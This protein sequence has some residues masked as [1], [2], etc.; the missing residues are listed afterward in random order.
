MISAYT[1]NVW[2]LP[3]NS[4]PVLAVGNVYCG[5]AEGRA[6]AKPLHPSAAGREDVTVVSLIR[7]AAAPVPGLMPSLDKQLRAEQK[8]SL[9]AKPWPSWLIKICASGPVSLSIRKLRSLPFISVKSRGKAPHAWPSEEEA[10]E[11]LEG[12]GRKSEIQIY[13][14]ETLIIWLEQLSWILVLQL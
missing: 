7:S 6:W 14:F 12:S 3:P 13:P 11:H 4:C 2:H 8:T 10:R 5:A 1:W 9:W